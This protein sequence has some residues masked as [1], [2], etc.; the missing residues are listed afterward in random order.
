MIYSLA[1][2]VQATWLG[3]MQECGVL[4]LH[5][6]WSICDLRYFPDVDIFR[7]LVGRIL[8]DMI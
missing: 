7:E 4:P 1:K 3:I 6:T 8:I 2:Y 5:C